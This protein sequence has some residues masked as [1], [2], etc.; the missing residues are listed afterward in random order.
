[1]KSLKNIDLQ[2]LLAPE[3][4]ALE[5]HEYWE[6]TPEFVSG[7]ERKEQSYQNAVHEVANS[8]YKR[9]RLTEFA[10]RDIVDELNAT[11]RTRP[12]IERGLSRFIKD[13][14]S[15]FLPI[16]KVMLDHLIV[17]L[18]MRE[19][20]QGP[21]VTGVSDI[22]RDFIKKAKPAFLAG[23][24]ALPKT[25]DLFRKQCS[26]NLSFA[27]FAKQLESKAPGKVGWGEIEDAFRQFTMSLL[28]TWETM[29]KSCSN[30]TEQNN[31][32]KLSA[33]WKEF[34]SVF[35]SKYWDAQRFYDPIV[36]MR[37][38]RMRPAWEHV[39]LNLDQPGRELIHISL[40]GKR[41]RDDSNI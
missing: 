15:H 40:Y 1:M 4:Q 27:A 8:A 2:S 5:W 31:I 35:E 19:A 9:M 28:P 11:R 3:R 6:L 38:L 14:F 41:K 10:G 23:A 29:R 12:V 18:R 32:A 20:E 26:E 17:P 37:K 13:V 22:A 34:V 30:P 25:K 39:Q 16:A 24:A 7:I 36:I 33:E 21:L